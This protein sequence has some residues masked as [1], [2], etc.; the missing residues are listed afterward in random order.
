MTLIA[1][2]LGPYLS[3]SSS[4][5]AF[6]WGATGGI[7]RCVQIIGADVVQRVAQ[8]TAHRAAV[9]PAKETNKEEDRSVRTTIATMVPTVSNLWC[10]LLC[11]G[12]VVTI[13]RVCL[14]LY[15]SLMKSRNKEHNVYFFQLSRQTCGSFVIT[16]FVSSN[17]SAPFSRPNKT[18][19][20][21]SSRRKKKK[22]WLIN[23]WTSH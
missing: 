23:L 11:P 21:L 3:A 7:R 4:S 1:S 6:P 2:Y 15:K 22:L 17:S 19:G 13:I 5:S 12:S 10:A 20:Y 16:K 18:R 9:V 14:S 8:P